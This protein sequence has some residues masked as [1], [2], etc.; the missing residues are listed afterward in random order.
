[1]NKNFIKSLSID[2]EEYERYRGMKN[3]ITTIWLISLS[4]FVKKNPQAT[5]YM[6]FMS[7]TYD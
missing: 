2:F 3:T 1:M 5:E 7:C 4:R 6:A